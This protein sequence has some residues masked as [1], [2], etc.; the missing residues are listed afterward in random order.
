[1][2]NPETSRRLTGLDVLAASLEDTAR[3]EQDGVIIEML[4]SAGVDSGTVTSTVDGRL[5]IALQNH[6]LVAFGPAE[7]GEGW[8]WTRYDAHGDIE[9]QGH[10]ETS[11]DLISDLLFSLSLTG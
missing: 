2:S 3:D 8:D 7:E 10:P 11:D 9:D 4:S 6:G 5:A 1:M